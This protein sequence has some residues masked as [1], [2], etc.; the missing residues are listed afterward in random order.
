M[1][2]RIGMLILLSKTLIK[3][4]IKSFSTVLPQDPADKVDGG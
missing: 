3:T 4:K 2:C 1:F